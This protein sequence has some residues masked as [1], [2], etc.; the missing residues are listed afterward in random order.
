[1]ASNSLIV[2]YLTAVQQVIQLIPNP[3]LEYVKVG[4]TSFGSDLR[5]ESKH[6]SL[7]IMISRD[8]SAET[9]EASFGTLACSSERAYATTLMALIDAVEAFNVQQ[10]L[11][12]LVREAYGE[13]NESTAILKCMVLFKYTHEQAQQAVSERSAIEGWKLPEA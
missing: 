4:D 6:W 11:W 8:I 3:E 7:S 9:W 12:T 10:H 13:Y 5:V 2:Q 1:M